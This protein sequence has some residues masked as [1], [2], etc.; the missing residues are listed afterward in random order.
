MLFPTIPIYQKR[1]S[2]RRKAAPTPPPPPPVALTLV[3]ATYTDSPASLT[4]TFDQAIDIAGLVGSQISVEDQTFNGTSYQGTG[5]AA[6]LNPT[7]VEITLTP[8]GPASGSDVLLTASGGTGIA[9]VDNEETWAGVTNQ[10][11]PFP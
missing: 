4:L 7:T 9:A 3:A 2:R 11:L 8:V 10:G 5:G 1:R 6:L